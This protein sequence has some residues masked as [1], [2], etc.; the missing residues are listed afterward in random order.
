MLIFGTK[1]LGV[2]A[3]CCPSD[4]IVN[5]KKKKIQIMKHFKIT[6]ILILENRR[7][8]KINVM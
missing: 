7:L 3:Y 6:D 8:I 1:L 4:T 5:Q 2:L